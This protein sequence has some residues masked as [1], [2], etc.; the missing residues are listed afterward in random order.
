MNKKKYVIILIILVAVVALGDLFVSKGGVFKAYGEAFGGNFEDTSMGNGKDLRYEKAE[1]VHVSADGVQSIVL[2][3]ISNQI[4]V[5]GSKGSDIEIRYTCKSPKPFDANG[6]DSRS[7][8]ITGKHGNEIRIDKN[9]STAQYRNSGVSKPEILIPEGIQVLSL[10][11][12]YNSITVSDFPG[13][14]KLNHFMGNL[15][16][17]NVG[18][19]EGHVFDGNLVVNGL[20]SK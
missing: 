10:N 19:M 12:Y 8:L 2:Y 1:V 7:I 4:V 17:N 20:G 14:V 15:A 16:L 3:D 18:S 5:R 13:T 6:I 11:D 9:D